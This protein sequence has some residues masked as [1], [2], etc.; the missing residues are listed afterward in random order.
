MRYGPEALTFGSQAMAIVSC[1]NLQPATVTDRPQMNKR[2]IHTL[3]G[4]VRANPLFANTFL[5][6]PPTPQN[7]CFRSFCSKIAARVQ[8]LGARHV[9]ALQ[10]PS[11]HKYKYRARGSSHIRPKRLRRKVGL[12]GWVGVCHLT[13]DPT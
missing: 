1:R 3:G 2:L 5:I 7:K 11:G 9:S 10:H 8:R 12:D 13:R 6:A 4:F